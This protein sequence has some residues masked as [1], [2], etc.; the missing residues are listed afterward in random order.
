MERT[1][2]PYLPH[3]LKCAGFITTAG[4]GELMN[5]VKTSGALAQVGDAVIVSGDVG[6][7]GC[8][9]LLERDEF[10]IEAEVTSDCAPLGKTTYFPVNTLVSPGSTLRMGSLTATKA[11]GTRENKHPRT[12]EKHRIKLGVFFSLEKQQNRFALYRNNRIKVDF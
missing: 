1:L 5:D 10:G 7:H 11:H 8:T 3:L 9:I 4:V 12:P 2:S 6:R